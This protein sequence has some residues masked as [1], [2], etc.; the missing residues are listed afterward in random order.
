MLIDT[1][2][3]LV[4]EQFNE[5]FHEV[6][7]RARDARIER[8]INIAYCPV[9]VEKAL[10][11]AEKN[12]ILRTALGIQPHDSH[13]FNQTTGEDIVS[14]LKT[15]PS[16]VA[17]GEIGLDNYHKQVPISQQ[18]PC[19]DFFLS[20]AVALKLPV[21]VHVRETHQEVLSF[22][23]KYVPL[24]LRGVIH[25]FTGTWEEAKD[26]LDLGFFIS[27]AG[28]VTFKNA[29]D[30]QTACRNVP[31]NSFL[32]ETDS[33]YLSPSPLRGKRNEPSHLVHTAKFISQIRSESEEI[34]IKTTTENAKKL[35][36]F[37]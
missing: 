4:S 20:A 25:C 30:L 31:Q 15:H 27:F 2:C 13:T 37:I 21:I 17:V 16:V 26:Y 10:L 6:L 11:Q 33:P 1:H 23:K 14:H 3:H 7:K 18:Q 19:F 8:I 32:I 12:P 35:F 34:T 28:I 36:S 22:L 29:I 5:D 24:G 9:T